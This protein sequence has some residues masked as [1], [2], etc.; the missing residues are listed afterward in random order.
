MRTS[1]DDDEDDDAICMMM[2]MMML[3]VMTIYLTSPEICFTCRIVSNYLLH[4]LSFWL[5]VCACA[6]V[7]ACAR[8]RACIRTIACVCVHV[9]M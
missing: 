7:R 9:R 2:M 3:M 6:C 1:N 8:E 4:L 5:R